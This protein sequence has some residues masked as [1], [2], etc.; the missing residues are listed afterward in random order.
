[1]SSH[2]T[3]EPG[4]LLGDG[5]M[6]ASLELVLDLGKLGPHTL[7]D[8]FALEPELPGLGLPANVREAQ[9][10]ER[11]W[12]PIASGF[13]IPSGMPS[14]LDEPRLVGMQFQPELRKPL[15]KVGEELPCVTLML[16][17]GDKVV[18]VPHDD[19][20]TVCMPASPLP[21]PPVEDVMEVDVGEQR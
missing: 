5:V 20:V 9:E 16:E 10:V 19:H 4:S 18:G 11:L 21:G 7:R 17:S 3:A 2:H 1:M 8:G 14:E 13:P 6:P 15:T 12:L